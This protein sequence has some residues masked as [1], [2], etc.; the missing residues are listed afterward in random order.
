V[1]RRVIEPHRAAA[2]KLVSESEARQDFVAQ[3]AETFPAHFV[4]WKLRLLDE[5][6]IPPAASEKDRG[7]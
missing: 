6:N 1:N 7:S 2:M 3:R 4:A 5:G